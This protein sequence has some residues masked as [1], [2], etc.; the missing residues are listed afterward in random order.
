MDLTHYRKSEPE[1]KRTED[2][3]RLVRLISKKEQSVLDIGAR[4]GHFSLLMTEFYKSVT[5]L[6]IKKPSI[7]HKNID[8]VCGDITNLDFSDNSY[9]LVFCAEVLEHIPSHLLGKACFELSRV[10]KEFLLIGVPYKQDIRIRRTTCMFC[11]KTN[12]PWGHVNS[13][14]RYVIKG[15]FPLFKV[16]EVSFVEKEHRCTNFISSFFMDLAGN[17]H[18]AYGEEEVCIHCGSKLKRPPERNLLQK[19]LTRAAIYMNNIQELFHKE[20]PYWIHILFK[21]IGKA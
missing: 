8:C 1:K 12:P 19:I 11:R 7:H 2:L 14:D 3:M 18:G 21:K 20:H 9:D 16:N 15:L 13:F 17:P 4:D 10:S 6:D 5:A